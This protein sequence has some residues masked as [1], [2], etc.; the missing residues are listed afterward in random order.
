MLKLASASKLQLD[1]AAGAVVL[2]SNFYKSTSGNVL[3]EICANSAYL[4]NVATLMQ[5]MSPLVLRREGIRKS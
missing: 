3:Q 5:A 4:L 1:A 2:D